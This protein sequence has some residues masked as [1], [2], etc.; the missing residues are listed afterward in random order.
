[1]NTQRSFTDVQN[2][3]LKAEQEKRIKVD[4]NEVEI[5]TDFGRIR[6]TNHGD[7]VEVFIQRN[8]LTYATGLIHEAS[9]IFKIVP[10]RP[11]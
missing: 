1:M 3:Q 6:I 8:Y 4:G 10:V 7:S 2:D 5:E 9:N 11:K